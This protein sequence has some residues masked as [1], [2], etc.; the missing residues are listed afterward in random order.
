[1]NFDRR[2]FAV[3][4]AV[5]A[6]FGGCA[7]LARTQEGGSDRNEAKG[8]GPL[9]RDPEGLFDLPD[10]FSYSVLSRAGDRMDDGFFTPDKFDGMGCLQLAGG[11][12]A[13]VRNHELGFADHALGP[14]RDDAALQARLAA[15]AHFDKGANGRVLPGG[16]STL[17]LDAK[18][19]AVVSQHLSL[20]GTSTNCAGG[21]TPWGTWLTCEET[22]VSAPN[23]GQSHGWIFEVPAG[24]KGL[25]AAQPL[26]AM[27]RFRHE[28][29]AVDSATGIVYLTE[30]MPDGLFY[31][32]IPKVRGQLAKGGKLQALAFVDG[33]TDSRNWLAADIAVGQSRKARW[34]DL[35][36]VESPADDLRLRGLAAGGVR[37][38]RGE[39]IH[40]GWTRDRRRQL[41]F[42]CTSGGAGR[43]GQIMRYEPSRFEGTAREGDEPGRLDLFVESTDPAVMDYADN[44]TVAPWGHLIVCEDRAGTKINH[45]RGVTP[46]GKCYALARLNADTELA[47]ACFSPDGTTL[48]VNVYKPGRT[49]A[50]TGPW[51]KF[52]A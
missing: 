32:F 38:A 5:I 21:A 27:G 4:A 18:T 48:F 47:G 9:R 14:A 10:G 37:F 19:L 31:R 35:D 41:F 33:G 8:Y 1:M 7:R 29:A 26:K 40:L 43:Y 36:D 51:R 20:A 46:E 42:T 28:A 34:I 23:T 6:A 49:L 16:T 39:G 12:I 44:I 22:L 17:I 15:A 13:L 24:A 30:D 11:R 52:A 2:S 50:I 45:L 3:S 25:V